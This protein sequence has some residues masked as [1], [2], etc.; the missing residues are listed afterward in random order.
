MTTPPDSNSLDPPADDA[1]VQGKYVILAVLALAVGASAISWFYY[2]RLQQRPIE[3]WGS[4]AAEL[5][6]RAPAARA[7]RLTSAG[8][9]GQQAEAEASSS[10][11][12]TDATGRKVQVAGE[13]LLA[14]DE[15]DVSQAPGFSHI[16]QSLIHD[17]SFAW[18]AEPGG[19][20]PR[21]E[22]AIEFQEN[23]DKAMVAFAPNC[24]RAALVGRDRTVSIRPVSAA[25]LD[26]LVEQYPAAARSAQPAETP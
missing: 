19:E 4:R 14:I 22:Y 10:H 23:G 25:I 26:F 8:A 20:P 1:G 6:L 18:E 17:R 12:T 16:R 5:M 11:E 15:R 21:W 13:S 3:L 24:G 9:T 2:A 7:Y